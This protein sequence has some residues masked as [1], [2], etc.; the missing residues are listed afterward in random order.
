VTTYRISQL[1]DRSGIPA[2]TLRYYES[3]GLLPA[4]RTRSGYRVYDDEAVERLA[5]ISS[6]KMLGLP[7]EEIR[8]LLGV[9]EL[10]ECAAVRSRLLPLVTARIADAEAR[11]AELSAFTA[12]LA[13]VHERL[14]E[15]APTGACGPGCGC[16][17]EA[18]QP[19]PVS[20]QLSRTRPRA[21]LAPAEAWRDAP[22]ACTLTG[23]EQGERT[24]E[25]RRLLASAL[26]H[27]SVPGGRRIT[28][29]TDPALATEL[30]RLAVL[31]QTCCSFYD[32]ALHIGP[33]ALAL[34][35][36]APDSAAD[37]VADLFG[38]LA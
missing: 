22:V 6:A 14:T 38:A 24:G 20:I 2:T 12:F 15:P 13:G 35:V 16:V 17:A 30:T 10:G 27:E 36:R 8:E 4:A 23:S 37:L 26:T 9:W 3:E 32:F 29:A 34:T 11:V 28:F 18:D 33:G 7:L 5:F 21:D 31:E 19:G 25:W 1:A